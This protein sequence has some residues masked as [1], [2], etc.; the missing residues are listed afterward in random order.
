MV[1]R[2]AKP[3]P[4]KDYYSITKYYG[5]TY[6]IADDDGGSQYIEE[7]SGKSQLLTKEKLYDGNKDGIIQFGNNGILD[8]GQPD[9]SSHTIRFYDINPLK[10]LRYLGE[11]GDGQY[12]YASAAVRPKGAIEGTVG[13]DSFTG[14]TNVADTFFFD[15]A[16]DSGS[17]RDTIANF[18]SEDRI[19]ST[20]PFSLDP[21]GSGD[22][23]AEG[24]FGGSALSIVDTS[25]RVA[26]GVT[27]LSTYQA[28][29]LTY[30][31][32]KPTFTTGATA[33]DPEF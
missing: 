3:V 20:L 23:V 2:A 18:G 27:L 28:H 17:G 21:F 15:G 1:L 8:L 9:A 26:D 4:S 12:V 5:N 25:G 7:F 13:Q 24:D 6:I 11:N 14:R 30:Y 19:I 33:P 29:G 32:Y 31:V 22:L 16:L 10:G